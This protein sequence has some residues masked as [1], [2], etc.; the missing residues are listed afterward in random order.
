MAPE[1]LSRHL[2]QLKKAG[3]IAVEGPV[4]RVLGALESS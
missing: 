3:L 1:T 2:A 4:I